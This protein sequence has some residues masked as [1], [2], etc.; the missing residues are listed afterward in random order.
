ML[1]PALQSRDEPR[2][3]R[4]CQHLAVSLASPEHLL[5]GGFSLA[6]VILVSTLR[7]HAQVRNGLLGVP[8]LQMPALVAGKPTHSDSTDT[9]VLCR[10]SVLPWTHT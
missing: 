4:A 10:G 2:I 6:D 9:R 5:P 7:P 3:Q 1:Q 8:S